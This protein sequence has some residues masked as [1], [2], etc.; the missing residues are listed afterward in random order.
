MPDFY[1]DALEAGTLSYPAVVSLL[2]GTRYLAVH[3]SR[4]SKALL[5]LTKYC[6]Q[7]LQKASGYRVYSTP[8]PC[9]IVAFAHTRLQS[10][11]VAHL[12]SER[13]DIAVR[14]G[15]HCSPL[16]HGALGTQED[17]LVR[18]SFSHYNSESDVNALLSAL[19]EIDE[20]APV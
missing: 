10:E 7:G 12:L 11:G 8:N 14:G 15:L 4:I 16:M 1:P 13:Y 9:G 17:G 18:V 19:R 2:E 3:Q 5:A 6:L 20:S